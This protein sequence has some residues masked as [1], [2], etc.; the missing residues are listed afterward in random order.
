MDVGKNMIYKGFL[1]FEI[2]SGI[3]HL[4]NLIEEMEK[5][6]NARTESFLVWLDK[7]ANSL[8]EDDKE[9]LYD[10]YI[11]EYFDLKKDFP[12][13]LRRAFISLSYSFFENQLKSICKSIDSNYAE[14]IPKNK[15]IP[16][17]KLYIDFISKEKDIDL[18]CKSDILKAIDQ[19][20]I[21]R[22][23][24]MHGYGLDASKNKNVLEIVKES[25]ELI[26]ENDVLYIS[27]KYVLD[28]IECIKDYLLY[29]ADNI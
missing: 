3:E 23:F 22:N 4:K 26:I 25:D 11:D 2:L 13:T 28:F 20:R 12:N 19:Y 21:V 27:Q 16:N 17:I 18:E 1:N 9:V 24:L 10:I 7:T 8:S 29:I 6:L 5:L 15:N 14:K